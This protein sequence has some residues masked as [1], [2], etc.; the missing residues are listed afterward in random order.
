MQEG[1]CPLPASCNVQKGKWERGDKEVGMRMRLSCSKGLF[2]AEH[3][4][5]ACMDAILC[6]ITLGEKQKVKL[7]LDGTAVWGSSGLSL[8]VGSSTFTG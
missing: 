2:C 7:P 3:W 5:Q 1:R 8:H 6:V 4:A